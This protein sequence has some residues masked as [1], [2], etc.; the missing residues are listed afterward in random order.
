MLSEKEFQ[1]SKPRHSKLKAF[2]Q[3]V[4][5]AKVSSRSEEDIIRFR[6]FAES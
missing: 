6:L 3:S 2:E 4:M 1:S 5:A